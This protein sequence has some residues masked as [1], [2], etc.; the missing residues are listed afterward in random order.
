MRQDS[1][2]CLH[3]GRSLDQWIQTFWLISVCLHQGRSSNPSVRFFSSSLKP[4]QRAERKQGCWESAA[5]ALGSR[6]SNVTVVIDQ[7]RRTIKLH[8]ERIK[9]FKQ[10]IHLCSAQRLPFPR[11]PTL[12]CS[13]TFPAHACQHTHTHAHARCHRHSVFS[14][15]LPTGT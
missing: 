9:C 14:S 12:S 15:P 1:G 7:S 2:G 11:T 4:L 6:P 8:S 3:T 13:A 10:E 5:A